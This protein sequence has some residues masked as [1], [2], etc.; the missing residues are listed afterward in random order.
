VVFGKVGSRVKWNDESLR[1]ACPFCSDVVPVT[2]TQCPS[3]KKTFTW[4]DYDPE[5]TPEGALNLVRLAFAYRDMNALVRAL[6]KDDVAKVPPA[7]TFFTS[8][9]KEKDQAEV[10]S[11]KVFGKKIVDATHVTLVVKGDADPETEIPCVLENG[12]WKLVM[13]EIWW[14]R[15]KRKAEEGLLKAVALANA[16]AMLKRLGSDD[17]VTRDDAVAKLIAMGTGIQMFVQSEMDRTTDPEVRQCCD[18]ILVVLKADSEAALIIANE[19]SAG[20]TMV[21][22]VTMEIFWR[23]SDSEGNGQKDFW[24]GDVSGLYRALDG[25]GN[26][27][28]CLDLAT[29]KADK[30]PLA[31]AKGGTPA[32]GAAVTAGVPVPKAGYLFQAMTRDGGGAAYQKDGPDKDSNAWENPGDYAFCAFPAEYGKTGKATFIVSGKGIV[33]KKDIGGKPVPAWPGDNPEK[34]GWVPVNAP[35]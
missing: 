25:R 33:Y 11:L 18:Q 17:A 21:N 5:N 6:C 4:G 13:L 12:K 27:V 30:A 15:G 29:A 32:M 35:K 31:A 3:C 24:T 23:E 16:S 28:K 7:T 14:V 34:D 8:D 1:P 26:P 9:I 22:L 20:R 2:S 19:Q 10:M